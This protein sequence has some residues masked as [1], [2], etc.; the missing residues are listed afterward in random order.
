MLGGRS[1]PIAALVK[2]QTRD[3]LRVKLESKDTTTVVQTLIENA[4]S[5]R[6]EFHKS[7]G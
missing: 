1:S 6:Q 2:R 7:L 5:L 4:R 3:V